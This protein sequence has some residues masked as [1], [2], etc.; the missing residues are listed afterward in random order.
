M[1]NFFLS[2][3]GKGIRNEA[4]PGE[5]T[6]GIGYQYLGRDIQATKTEDYVKNLI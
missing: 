4:R 5:K 3:G 2:S 6:K 1:D